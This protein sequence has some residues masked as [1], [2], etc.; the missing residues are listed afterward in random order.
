MHPNALKTLPSG[1]AAAGGAPPP[2]AGPEGRGGK[3]GRGG[4]GRGGG[5]EGRR[6]GEGRAKGDP[7]EERTPPTS[8]SSSRSKASVLSFSARSAKS[9]AIN[10][11]I[12]LDVYS[13]N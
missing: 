13:R 10:L 5:G 2:L 7:L 9:G 8:C 3:G 12:N 4:E 6:G 1:A 11:K